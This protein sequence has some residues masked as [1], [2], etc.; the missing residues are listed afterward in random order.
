MR[1]IRCIQCGD[2][3]ASA[4]L[5]LCSECIRGYPH[6]SNLCR[7]HAKYRESFE[8]PPSIPEDGDI[9]CRFCANKCKPSLSSYGYCG[10]RIN[11]DGRIKRKTSQD[12]ALAHAYL[13]PLPTNCCASWF[14]RGSKERGY[15][16]AVFFYGCGFDCLFC[17]N[18]EHKDVEKAPS[19]SIDELVKKA[20]NPEVRCIC[21]FGGSP[22]PQ[23]DF[24]LRASRMIINESGNRKHICWEWNGSGN[25][26]MVL[27]AAEISCIS[28][29]TVKFDLKAW[30][31]KLHLALCGIDNKRTLENFE[32]L[33]KEFRKAPELLTATTLMV[34]YYVDKREVEEIASF[35]S[36]IDRN[37]PY[38]LL[39]FHPDFVLDDLPPTPKSQANECYDVA[40]KYLTMVNIGNRYLLW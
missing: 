7:L 12:Y 33:G 26:R 5:T 37:I 22:E 1:V 13:D 16:L 24:A 36:G 10:I 20:L 15:N 3:Y 28:G 23:M 18:A 30:D 17:Q 31:E 32:M 8:L 27:K 40:K 9:E 34:S 4:S 2:G 19:L 11:R 14:C 35:I 6:D 25:P 29:G 21:F 39:A 38:S